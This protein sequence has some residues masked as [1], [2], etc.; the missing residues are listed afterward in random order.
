MLRH[1]EPSWRYLATSWRQDATQEREEKQKC[2]K[3]LLLEIG[4]TLLEIRPRVF[5]T[6]RTFLRGLEC[7]V[8][9]LF[10]PSGGR[11]GR[12]QKVGRR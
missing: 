4:Q 7:R 12:K 10:A 11:V 1:L 2:Q 5:L 6:R 8:G 9:T 3:P